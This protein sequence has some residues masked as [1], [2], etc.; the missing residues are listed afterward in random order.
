VA[1]NAVAATLLLLAGVLAGCNDGGEAASDDP[2]PAGAFAGATCTGPASFPTG[3]EA[4]VVLRTNFGDLVLELYHE[5]VPVT[6]D[7][8]LQLVRSGY[9]NGTQFHRILT[10][11]MMQGGQNPDRGR[12]AAIP[13]ELHHGLRHDR[14]GIL[15]M[16]NAGPNTGSSQFFIL[17]A[18]APHLDDRHTVFGRVKQGM[19]VLDSIE[20]EAATTADGQPPRT[21]VQ[22]VGAT[23]RKEPQRGSTSHWPT[24]ASI[25]TSMRCG[26]GLQFSTTVRNPVG[27]P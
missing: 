25:V 12:V 27:P 24:S 5:A 3:R 6:V 21:E 4:E 9:Y 11:F 18:P 14:K 7:N 13:D 1:R 20:R 8:F 17:F 23:V 22:L 16:A 26:T 19:D 2:V 10:G 15:S